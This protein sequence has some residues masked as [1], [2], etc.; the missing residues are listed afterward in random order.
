MAAADLGVALRAALDQQARVVT[1]FWL[2]IIDGRYYAYA[3][4]RAAAEWVM[5]MARDCTSAELK[6]LSFC[7]EEFEN[8]DHLWMVEGE[9]FDCEWRTNWYAKYPTTEQLSGLDDVT[10]KQVYIDR[11]V[12]K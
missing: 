7:G 12:V 6:P 10:I 11:R 2:T 1:V 8:V 9:D 4:L 5:H 3:D